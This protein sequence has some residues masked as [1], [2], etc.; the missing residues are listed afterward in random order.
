MG[1]N[2]WLLK[3]VW[4][5]PNL[6]KNMIS[7]GQ[8]GGEGC[9]TT[10]TD[11]TWK[12]T[13]GSLV[14]TKGGKVGTLYLCNGIYNSVNTLTSTGEDTTLWHHRLGHMSEKGMQILH[15]RNL[16]PGKRLKCLRSDNGG[17]YCSKE[18]DRYYSENGIHREKTVPGTPQENVES[19]R[20]NT[21]IMERARCMRLHA[22]LPLQ[23][24]ADAVDTAIY[25]INRGPS[26]SLDGGIPEEAWIGKKVN[27]SFLKTF[28]Y[29]AFVHIKKENRTKLEEKSKKCTFI[30]YGVNGLGY[31]L[32][33]YENHKI[34]RS[35]DVIFNEKVLYK[36]QL[37]E[38]K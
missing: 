14:I 4:H 38:K 13:K 30:G 36:N 21:T 7:T 17:G 8:L 10:F 34:I 18:F 35:R 11:K 15:S 16:L 26:S 6:K 2:Q 3:E 19:K 12:V 20:M 24:W 23:F 28:S 33:Y 31:R 32:Y 5:V 22:G 29:E 25:L 27:Y 37:Q 9:V 1:G